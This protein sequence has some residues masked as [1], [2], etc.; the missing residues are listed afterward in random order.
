MSRIQKLELSLFEQAQAAFAELEAEITSRLKNTLKI[1][2]GKTYAVAAN[3]ERYNFCIK[4]SIN[5]NEYQISVQGRGA[6]IVKY[7]EGLLDI[8]KTEIELAT[9]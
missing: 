7:N 1:F 4:I 6:E 2:T 9:A 3:F 5:D 8:L